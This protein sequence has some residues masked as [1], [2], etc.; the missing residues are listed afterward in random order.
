MPNVIS[1]TPPSYAGDPNRAGRELCDYLFYLVEQL[2]FTLSRINA[3]ET[4]LQKAIEELK[5]NG[6]I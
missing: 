6:G 4:E 2:N 1:K 5:G 3:T